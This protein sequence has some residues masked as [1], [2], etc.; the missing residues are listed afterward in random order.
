M[1]GFPGPLVHAARNLYG[2]A[3][4]FM[5]PGSGM[6][7]KIAASFVQPPPVISGMP[8]PECSLWPPNHKLVQVATVTAVSGGLAL[9]SFMVTGTSNEP[10]NDPNDLEIVITPDGSGGFVV[11][12]QAERLRAHTGFPGIRRTFPEPPVSVLLEPPGI[13]LCFSRPAAERSR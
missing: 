10:S 7:F 9:G 11:Q 13:L 8:G 3:S 5:A 12:L 2:T 6:V 4:S 1:V